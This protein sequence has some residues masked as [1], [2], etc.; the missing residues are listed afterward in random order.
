[1]IRALIAAIGIATAGVA[2]ATPA[3]A[4]PDCVDSPCYYDEDTGEYYDA[5]DADYNGGGGAVV[6]WGVYPYVDVCAGVET[7]IPFVGGEVCTG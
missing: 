2:L 3:T 7:V 4:E 5:G 6:D 1:M